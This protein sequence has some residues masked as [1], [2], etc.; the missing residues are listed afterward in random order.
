MCTI[1]KSIQHVMMSSFKSNKS[2]EAGQLGAVGS[3]VLLSV[4]RVGSCSA[5]LGS[6]ALLC[7]PWVVGRPMH[8]AWPQA[9]VMDGVCSPG[10]GEMFYAVTRFDSFLLINVELH[11]TA[12]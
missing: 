5:F 11:L 2:G 10:A 4:R 9:V 8:P 3:G 1:R 7:V 12:R 6:G